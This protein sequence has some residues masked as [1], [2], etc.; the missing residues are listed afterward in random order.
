MQCNHTVYLKNIQY[1][2]RRMGPETKK[3]ALAIALKCEPKQKNVIC[4]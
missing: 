4:H 2:G 1:L 3:I